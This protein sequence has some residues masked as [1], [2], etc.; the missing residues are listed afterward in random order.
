MVQGQLFKKQPCHPWSS[1]SRYVQR[2]WIL[3]LIEFTSGLTMKTDLAPHALTKSLEGYADLFIEFSFRIRPPLEAMR[4]EW[5]Q[6]VTPL[7]PPWWKCLFILGYDAGYHIVS[8]WLLFSLVIFHMSISRAQTLTCRRRGCNQSSFLRC[9]EA[10][11]RVFN[12]HVRIP[13]VRKFPLKLVQ[14]HSCHPST[15]FEVVFF[16]WEF[17][18]ILILFLVV[19][20]LN[21]LRELVRIGECLFGHETMMKKL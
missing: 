9:A 18:L 12:T 6:W 20:V 5:H 15:H 3:F 17:T 13:I 1:G 21:I 7:N 16:P 19:L 2:V 11:T 4:Q 10:S 8:S 14:W